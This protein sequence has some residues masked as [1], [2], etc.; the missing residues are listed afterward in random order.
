MNISI[1]A[2]RREATIIRAAID[3]LKLIKI[4]PDRVERAQSQ[5][6][7]TKRELSTVCEMINAMLVHS[8]REQI[9]ERTRL[10]FHCDS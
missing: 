1:V 8:I 3:R 6:E 9:A 7:R 10:V 2:V 5:L 4:T